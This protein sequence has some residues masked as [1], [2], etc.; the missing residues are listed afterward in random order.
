VKVTLYTTKQGIQNALD[1]KT[2]F[3]EMKRTAIS[4]IEITVNSSE[5]QDINDDIYV[6]KANK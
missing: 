3:A 5:I 2:L 1:G 6:I 4:D